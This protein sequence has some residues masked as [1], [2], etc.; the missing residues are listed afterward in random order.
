MKT[1]QRLRRLAF[2][3]AACALALA[4]TP[5]LAASVDGV[6]TADPHIW[7]SI[8]GDTYAERAHFSDGVN[9][10]TARLDKQIAELRA[11]RA[12][13]TTDTKDWDFSMK[14]IEESRE[15]LA[16]KIQMLLKADT[17]E[18]WSDA[19]DK[20]GDEWN[21]AEAAVDKMNSTVTS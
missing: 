16:S 19:K 12:T 14:A 2:A 1:T 15:A 11:K 6:D 21:R 3:A 20:I 8:K 18:T 7:T 5:A 9:R 10:M 17:P 13:M 4:G